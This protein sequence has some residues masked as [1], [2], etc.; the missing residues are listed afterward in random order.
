MT[1]FEL[2]QINPAEV[3][4]LIH[5]LDEYLSPLYPPESHHLDTIEELSGKNVKMFGCKLN[6]KMVAIG[7]VKLMGDYGELKRLYVSPRHRR[8]GLAIAILKR[9]E[10]EILKK[11]LLY[12]RLETGIHQPEVLNLCKNNGYIIRKPFGNYTD[13]PF[14]IFMEKRLQPTTA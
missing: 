3:S 2:I 4:G 7:A 13:D 8:K 9:L 10:T 11:G 14:S 6:E 5:E 1:T 12:A